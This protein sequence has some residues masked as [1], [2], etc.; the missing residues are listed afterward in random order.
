MD[1]MTII[2]TT[3]TC[4]KHLPDKLQ[5][6]LAHLK[7]K[8]SISIVKGQLA[9]ER[10]CISGE[11]YHSAALNDAEQVEQL[12]GHNQR[13]QADQQHTLSRQTEVVLLPLWAATP[14]NVANYYL[15][16][17]PNPRQ[18]SGKTGECSSRKWDG[19]PRCMSSVGVYV[20]GALSLPISSLV[21]E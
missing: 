18:L 11:K 14:S 5:D 3:K 20:N 2:T 7:I 10:F 12:A 9:N 13:P 19:L 1:D 17:H 21:E 4:T 6:N 16:G 15:Q 8:L